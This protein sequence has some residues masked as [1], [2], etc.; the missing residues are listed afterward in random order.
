MCI[1]DST[2]T[3]GLPVSISNYT[4][5]LL[6]VVDLKTGL[7]FINL[8]TGSRVN[9]PFPNRLRKVLFTGNDSLIAF[10]DNG[11]IAFLKL[12]Y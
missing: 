7:N 1:R 6:T 12:I 5:S 2:N 4:E 11:K 10:Y 8:K 3:G 9:F